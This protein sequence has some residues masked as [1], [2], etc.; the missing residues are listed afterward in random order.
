MRDRRRTGGKR[1]VITLAALLSLI[2]GY[3]LGQQW[4]RQP[5]TDLSATVYA[6]GVAIDYPKGLERPAGFHDVDAWR[7][8]MAFDARMP[9]C[10]ERLQ[11]AL[12]AVNRLAPQTTLQART[13]LT[14]LLYNDSEGGVREGLR[15]ERDRIEIITGSNTDLDTIT[16]R[17]GTLPLRS[18]W[19]AADAGGLALISPQHEAWALIPWET[20][21]A[22]AHNIATIVEFLE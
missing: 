5:L 17:V 15:G 9:A 7:L 18:R 20:P 22:M 12:L 4:Q 14:L 19:C 16:G 3:Y 10:S 11:Q 8:F 1:L 13:R 2:I 21:A 6:N